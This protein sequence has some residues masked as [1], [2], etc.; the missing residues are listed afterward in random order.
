MEVRMIRGSVP[1]RRLSAL[2]VVITLCSAPIAS[3]QSPDTAPPNPASSNTALLRPAAFARLV[4][5][6]S[7]VVRTPAVQDPPRIDLRRA[8]AA[9]TPSRAPVAHT[10]AKKRQSWASRHPGV[11]SLIIIAAGTFAVFLLFGPDD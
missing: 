8:V 11:V 3:A 10:M 2:S 7:T 9:P 5:P 6:P 1:L 4:Q